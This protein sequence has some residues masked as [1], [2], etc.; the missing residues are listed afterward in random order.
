MYEIWAIVKVL[1]HISSLSVGVLV[2]AKVKISK[3]AIKGWKNQGCQKVT[4]GPKWWR[5][6]CM[7]RSADSRGKLPTVPQTKAARTR[8]RREIC[9]DRLMLLMLFEGNNHPLLPVCAPFNKSNTEK[10]SS[11]DYQVMIRWLMIVPWTTTA[12]GCDVKQ[13]ATPSSVLEL[14]T[15]AAVY[16]HNT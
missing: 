12:A 1:I 3:A 6:V 7:R 9:N 13:E 10:I 5:Q 14:F 15:P 11:S 4:N 8:A 16:I 2:A